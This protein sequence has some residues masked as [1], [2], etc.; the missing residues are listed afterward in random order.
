[1]Y[2][3][4]DRLGRYLTRNKRPGSNATQASQVT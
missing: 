1:V 3:Y 4:M 2:L